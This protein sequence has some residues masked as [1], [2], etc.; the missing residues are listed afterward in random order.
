MNGG[1]GYGPELRDG[2]LFGGLAVL[3]RLGQGGDPLVRVGLDG[4]HSSRRLVD[5]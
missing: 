4:H 5:L 2:V 3:S 1:E